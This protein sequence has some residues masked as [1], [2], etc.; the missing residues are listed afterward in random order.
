VTAP[1]RSDGAFLPE[2][3]FV[4]GLVGLARTLRAWGDAVAVAAG[5]DAGAPR[6]AADHPLLL[7]L[8]GAA[9]L[10]RWGE[11]TLTPALAAAPPPGPP[12][13]PASA[14]DGGSLLR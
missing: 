3:E 14:L 2:P 11:R 9:A 6:T 1:R 4:H 13:E 5:D 10:A 12:A 7:A 8:L